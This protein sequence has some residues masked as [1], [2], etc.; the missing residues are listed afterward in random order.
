MALTGEPVKKK[1]K[2]SVRVS[3]WFQVGNRVRHLHKN[4]V[5]TVTKLESKPTEAG[6]PPKV[7]LKWDHEKKKE[8]K[9]MLARASGTADLVL[10]TQEE[11]VN[12]V[13]AKCEFTKVQR[14]EFVSTPIT[15]LKYEPEQAAEAAQKLAELGLGDPLSPKWRTQ[16]RT[17]RP[18]VKGYVVCARCW[19]FLTIHRRL[20]RD[21]RFSCAQGPR[22]ALGC[23][24]YLPMQVRCPA[25]LGAHQHQGR[26]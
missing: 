19:T 4:Y 16:N 17:F 5:G 14:D 6:V 2:K 21:H 18:V 23:V 10:I 26:R 15:S 20:T 11:V 1:A 25:S 13:W 12:E 9:T 24:Y 22:R 3:K 7:F 8:G